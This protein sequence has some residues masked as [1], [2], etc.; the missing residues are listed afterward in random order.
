M[1]YKSV[2]RLGLPIWIVLFAACAAPVTE[3]ER[4]GFISDYSRLEKVGSTAYLYTGPKVADY[5]RFRIEGPAILFDAASGDS[6]NFTD[7]ELEEL[8]Y[9]FREQLTEALT[10]KDGYT[11]VDQPGAGVATIRLGITAVDATVGAL[12]VVLTTKITGAGLGGAA[13]EG[14]MVDSLSGEQ[15]A[16]AVQWGSGS[17]I[18]RAG[19]TRLGDAK[20]QINR[21]TRNLRKRIDAAHVQAQQTPITSSET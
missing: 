1:R 3:Q 7:E 20:L 17:R 21:W 14:E 2:N 19:F 8:E 13:M 10:E 15:L 11:V 18:L 12:N 16:A 6:D 4:T 5:S 9:Y